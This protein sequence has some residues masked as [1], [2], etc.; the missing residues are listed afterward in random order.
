LLVVVNHPS[1]RPP[2]PFS[3]GLEYLLFRASFHNVMIA[4]YLP[5]MHNM[6]T[7]YV[8]RPTEQWL[9]LYYSLVHRTLYIGGINGGWRYGKN[10]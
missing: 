3:I 6:Q 4:S 9:S 2:L 8:P 10:A 5:D 7:L 1:H